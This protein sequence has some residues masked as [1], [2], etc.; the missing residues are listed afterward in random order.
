MV[1]VAIVDGSGGNPVAGT[2]ADILRIDFVQEGLDPAEFE[3]P[4]VDGSFDVSIEF[5]SLTATTRLRV[6]VSGPTT[7]LLSAPP[8][9]ATAEGFVRL[10][11]A[12][13]SSCELVTF[14]TIGV[15]RSSLGIVRAGTFVFL[16]GGTQSQT[17]QLGF[18]DILQWLAVG[19]DGFEPPELP[20]LGPTRA[21]LV[22]ENVFF[23]LP[24]SSAPFLFNLDPDTE[25][26][27]RVVDVVL[28]PGA[29]PSSAL[30]SVPDRGAMVIGG[31]L[32]DTA[33]SGVSLVRANGTVQFLSLS[34]PRSG[35]VATVFGRDV[36]V[37]GGDPVG[38][39]ELLV[40]GRS[41]G[42]PVTGLSDGARSNGIIV[43]DGESR[44]LL[45]GGSDALGTVRQD[46]VFFTGCPT[47]CAQQAG[48]A[49]TDARLEVS[50]PVGSQLLIGGANSTLVDEV[51][52]EG[53]DVEVAA[54]LRLQIPRAAAAGILLESGA[55][56]V[57]GGTDGSTIRN[58]LEFC[59]PQAL[60]PL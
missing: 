27:E 9:F 42:E 47:A 16:A 17:D 31:G 49:W 5:L 53:G 51:Q 15:P 55:F 2:D 38:N 24:E 58:D 1:N 6:E 8:A 41:T 54:L 45:L 23:V 46:T 57:A 60:S 28:H 44:A 18:F 37:V 22:E 14:E 7:N 21:A 52:F 40:D 33:Q 11:A 32:G 50:Q 10:V 35:A 25:E 19:E 13:P 12:E 59:V 4:I 56:I 30:V 48:P 43:G 36:L 34:E 29:G 26:D 39:A 20:V 3:F